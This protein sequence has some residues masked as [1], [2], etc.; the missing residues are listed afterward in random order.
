MVY[1][2]DGNRYFN[3]KYNRCGNSGLMLP[4]ISLGYWHNFG[5]KDNFDNMRRMTF[6]AFDLGLPILTWRT[7]MDRLREVPRKISE[8]S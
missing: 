3:M 2:P 7:I 8:K 1:V 4:A 6:T 5:Y